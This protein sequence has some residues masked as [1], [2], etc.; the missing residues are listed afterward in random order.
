MNPSERIPGPHVVQNNIILVA[1]GDG[2][3][4]FFH[5]TSF[6]QEEAINLLNGH[7]NNVCRFTPPGEDKQV[8]GYASK[9]IKDLETGATFRILSNAD[10]SRMWVYNVNT[11]MMRV[12]RILPD[13][14]AR[15]MG[16]LPI[17][18]P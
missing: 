2:S 14:T 3:G 1:S 5:A 7:S 6:Q 12:L 8:E 15:V 13:F 10:C 16:R 9:E 4:G 11:M 17:F 18:S